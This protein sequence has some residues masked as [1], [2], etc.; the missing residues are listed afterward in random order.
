MVINNT[1]DVQAQTWSSNPFL[2]LKDKLTGNRTNMTTAHN[3]QQAQEAAEY[4]QSLNSKILI[5][6][7]NSF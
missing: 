4:K 3:T 7:K 1:W 5:C 6:L 2:Q